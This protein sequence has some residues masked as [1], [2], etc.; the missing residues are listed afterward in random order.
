M[1]NKQNDIWQENHRE[2]INEMSDVLFGRRSVGSVVRE[3]KAKACLKDING[4]HS[5]RDGTDWRITCRLCGAKR[6]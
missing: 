6:V 3:R 4:F 2:L 1:S 5:F